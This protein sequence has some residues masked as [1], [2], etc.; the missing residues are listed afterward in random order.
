MSKACNWITNSQGDIVGAKINGTEERSK[1]FDDLNEEFGMDKAM[2]LFAVSESTSFKDIFGG[3]KSKLDVTVFSEVLDKAVNA[4]TYEDF[5]EDMSDFRDVHSAPSKS[6]TL[7]EDKL[8]QGGDFSLLEVAQG[9]HNQPDD[10]FDPNVGA[11]YYMYNNK[12]GME[13][14]TAINNVI[15]GIKAGKKGINITAYRAVP[16]NL[17]VTTL[18]DYDWVSFSES[19]AISH[20]ESRFGSKGYKLIEQEVSLQ[21]LW[22]DGN[23]INEFGRF[24]DLKDTVDKNKAKAYFEK[25]EGINIP[26][27][28]VN[29]R[30]HNLLKKFIIS[31]GFD[32]EMPE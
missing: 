26:P 32:V 9:F 25:L 14:F 19:Y 29:I 4:R 6:T 23:D 15:R 1:L 17:D 22:W 28:K 11:R 20:G 3:N 2:E 12:Q 5:V 24:D 30:V 10:Y 21:D 7:T 27:F 16:K 18:K 13:S 31:G 8:D